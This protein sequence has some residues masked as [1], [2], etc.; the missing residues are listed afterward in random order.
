[1]T[2]NPQGGS[3]G[4]EASTSTSVVIAAYNSEHC[5]GATLDSLSAQTRRPGEVIVVDDGS[6]DGT[7]ALAHAHPAVDR[8]IP[9]ENAGYCA[10]RNTGIEAARGD[11]LFILDSDDL[12]HPVYVERMVAMMDAHPEA[13]TGFA[14]YT[15]WE[16]PEEDPDPFEPTIESTH[17]PL[18][19]GGFATT[20]M[21]GLPYLPS[22][23]VVRR[24]VLGRL[25]RRPYREDQ[26]QGEAAYMF[27][28]FAAIAPCVEHRESIGRYR[29]HAN[30]VTGDE[31]DAAR[32]VEPCIDDLREAAGGGLGLG[33]R[34]DP[35][36]IAAI[37]RHSADWY[38]RCGRRLGGGGDRRAGR[39]QLRKAALLGDARS[40]ALLLA[41]FVP[42]LGRRA[43]VDSWRPD[44][45]R[46]SEGVE[47]WRVQEP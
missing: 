26:V 27:A 9:Q 12:W 39:R 3:A 5:L 4:A 8:V 23:H 47:A 34:F 15:T 25:G 20:M 6:E 19:F 32:R 28:L 42:G 46:R 31:M 38:R 30:A 45:V 14:R 24:E 37:D 44:S 40:A 43:W 36:A 41:T 33:L 22:F 2:S 17:R 29:M 35:A 10:A 1:M 7:A 21:Q 13:G 16:H 11:L 18:D